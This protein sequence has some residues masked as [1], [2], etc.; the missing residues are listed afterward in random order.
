LCAFFI[1]TQGCGCIG[2]P[3]FP[4]P[5]VIRGTWFRHSSDAFASREREAAYSIV[6][7]PILRDAACGRSSESDSKSDQQNQAFLHRLRHARPCAGHPRP[8]SRVARK[9]VDGR[10]KPGHDGKRFNFKPLARARKTSRFFG[11]ALRMR[12]SYMTLKVV[13]RM[14]RSAIR[15]QPIHL[16]CCPGF[17][18]ACHRA[19]IRATRWL[20]PGY[21]TH[22]SKTSLR[23][24]K[25]TKQS[26]I[27]RATLDCLAIA[28]NDDE[29]K[30]R[31]VAN[32]AT[33]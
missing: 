6:S 15:D 11:Q 23:G 21:G 31:R 12:S 26:R 27:A 28:R 17:R 5:S 22:V 30:F 33:T 10:D 3:A 25:A 19:R 9:D 32:A 2:H 13:A 1:R 7:R 16:R 24:A 14:E 8:C 18:G 4:A 20:H 29:R